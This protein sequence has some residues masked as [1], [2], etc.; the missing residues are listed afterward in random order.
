MEWKTISIGLDLYGAF[1]VRKNTCTVIGVL[2]SAC[3]G[4]DFFM[5]VNITEL[6][7]IADCFTTPNRKGEDAV[8][9][10]QCYI[11]GYP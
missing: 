1:F 3:P 8:E 7:Y 6:F 5:Y 10:W 11:A 2:S 4:K 9:K